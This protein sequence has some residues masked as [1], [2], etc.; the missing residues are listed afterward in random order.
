MESLCTAGGLLKS[1]FLAEAFMRHT[2]TVT[3]MQAMRNTP[4]Q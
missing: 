4:M 1:G 3:T 2:T